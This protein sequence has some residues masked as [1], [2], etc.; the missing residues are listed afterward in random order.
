MIDLDKIREEHERA[1]LER[2]ALFEA[3]GIDPKDF[4]PIDLTR[5]NPEARAQLQQEFGL[6][7]SKV[8]PASAKTA[9]QWRLRTKAILC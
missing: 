2:Q 6:D 9:S 7:L 3:A 1:L 5:I 8:L 4:P